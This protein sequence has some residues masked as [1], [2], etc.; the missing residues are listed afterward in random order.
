M[1]LRFLLALMAVLL[2]L[3]GCSERTE[4]P[5]APEAPSAAISTDVDLTEVLE[6]V[7]VPDLT[8]VRSAS[9]LIRASEGGSVE[10]NGFRVDIP[11]GAL[12]Q[13][14]V[15]TL[16]LP[17]D[18]LLGKHLVAELLPHGLQFNEPVTLTFPLEG[19]IW[20]GEP[21][22]VGRWENDAWTSLGG[23]VS[24]DGKSLRSTTPHFSTYS[25]KLVM[26]GG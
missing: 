1:T 26:A 8:G 5:L 17:R 18:E 4:A 13:D 23:A 12:P 11:A 6:F 9:K 14:T 10:L 24:P 2:P 21:I 22:E 19:V 16:E 7:T 25:G 20:T 3:A 15:I